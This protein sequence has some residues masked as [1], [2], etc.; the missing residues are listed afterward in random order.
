MDAKQF[1]AEFS[2]IANS[3]DG[4]KRLRE[5]V[6]NLAVT[7]NLTQQV[8]V[9]GNAG[10]LME[11]INLEKTKRIR[12]KRFKCSPKFEKLVT[13]IPKNIKLPQHWVWTS[14]VSIGE[15][16][17]KN[18]ADNNLDVSFIPMRGV[19]Q[20]HLGALIPEQKKWG[21]IKKGYTQFAN[22]D[23][24][25]AKITPCFEN[26]KSA[27]IGGLLNSIGAGTTELHVVRPLPGVNPKYIYVF[28][29]SPYF[30][31]EGELNMT[32]TAGQKR[33]TSDYFA[34]RAFPLPPLAEQNRI[35]EK[36][37]E[38]MDLCNKLEEQQLQKR[39]LQ[40][41]LR[42]SAFQAVAIATSPFELKL[43]WLRLQENFD[44]LFSAPEDVTD[45]KGLLLDL[46][47]NGKMLSPEQYTKGSTGNTVLDQIECSRVKWSENSFD[48][49][50]KEAKT[51][52]TKLKKQNV[53][54]PKDELPEHWQW[55][56]L[57]QISKVIIDCDHKTP[58]YTNNGTHLI[59]TTDIR[60]GRMTLTNTKK[61]S[62]DGYIQ[63]SRRLVPTSGDIFFTREAPMG[64]AAIVPENEI[65]SL[66]QR[67]M[68]VRLFEEKYDVNF[69]IYVIRSPS[70]QKRL[71]ENAVGM[72]VKHINVGKVED[73]FVPVPPKQEQKRI[74]S[75]LNDFFDLCEKLE[76]QLLIKNKISKNLASAFI[77][78]LTGVNTSLEEEPLKVPKTELTAPVTLGSNKPNGKDTAPLA[79]L[80]ARQSGSMNATD[81]WQSFSGEIDAFYA[82][83]KT[84]IAHGWIA[85]PAKAKMLEKD[86]E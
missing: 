55:A 56:T 80:L 36:V 49:E 57:L 5:M 50:L 7:G 3:I 14:L 84:E 74:V 9:E 51:M 42:Q 31:V 25:I 47:V 4:V 28:L 64:E 81:L 86:E 71:K 69:L 65:V 27:V 34:S 78:T 76:Q 46:A 43:H 13:K 44:Q 32:G 30:M 17:P 33:L 2:H 72:T 58:V 38:L 75:T 21:K 37:N 54:Y 77:T 24:V 10:D 26:G 22:G 79:A 40:N 60:N 20:L 61:I 59:R 83:L 63:R 41:Q 39:Q 85:E 45:F 1:L 16:S 52:L 23:V 62:H 68:L 67:L 18:E 29:R 8:K 66:G 48:Q 82:Q 73:L 15:I 70:F 19:S 35:V 11:S 53:E 12:A 6:Y